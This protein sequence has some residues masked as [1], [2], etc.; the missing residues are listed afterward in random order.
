[1]S[2]PTLP[3][4]QRTEGALRTCSCDRGQASSKMKSSHSEPAASSACHATQTASFGPRQIGVPTSRIVYAH[5][6]ADKH[7]PATTPRM[8]RS[9]S[10]VSVAAYKQ[11]RLGGGRAASAEHS[12]A[13]RRQSGTRLPA[14][15]DCLCTHARSSSAQ[16]LGANTWEVHVDVLVD[17]KEWSYARKQGQLCKSEC[18]LCLRHKTR[19]QRGSARL[20]FICADRMSDLYISPSAKLQCFRPSRHKPAMHHSLHELHRLPCVIT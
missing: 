12:S 4:T 7:T 9:R 5:M 20:T 6:H 3:H 16:V 11:P 10:L 13:E 14:L 1:M 17:D 8:V 19:R 18:L 15:L 2:L